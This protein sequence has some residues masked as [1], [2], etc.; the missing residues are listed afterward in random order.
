M[1]IRLQELLRQK[2]LVQ[3]H[4]GW[5]DEQI[6][7]ARRELSSGEASLQEHASE[8]LLPKALRK[9]I[10]ATA[11]EAAEAPVPDDDEAASAQAVTTQPE[12]PEKEDLAGAAGP[13]P[14]PEDFAA[15]LSAQTVKRQVTFGL[16]VAAFVLVGAAVL[17]YLLWPE[18]TPE[19]QAAFRER[20]QEQRATPGD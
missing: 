1:K 6:E 5:L 18:W 17:A 13:T 8:P 3:K 16:T 10:V 2:A 7:A 19:E 4:L 11:P 20:M 15:P 9:R 14:R 12:H